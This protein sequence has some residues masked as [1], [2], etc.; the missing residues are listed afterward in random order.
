MESNQTQIGDL[1]AFDPIPKKIYNDAIDAIGKTPLIRINK[2]GKT[3]G[4]ECE[5]LAKC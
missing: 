2:I 3:E 1:N 4:I 5:I